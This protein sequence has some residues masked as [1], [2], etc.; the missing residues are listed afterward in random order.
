ME[1]ARVI[2]ARADIAL[3]ATDDGGL[4]AAMETP[5]RSL[6]L[7]TDAG[8]GLGRV[9]VGVSISTSSGEPLT[10]GKLTTDARLDFWVDL[11][12]LYLSA[13]QDFELR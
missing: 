13:G 7:H 12:E 2:A 3:L 9:T 1:T 11:A 8:P 4:K 5:C 10:P 6:L